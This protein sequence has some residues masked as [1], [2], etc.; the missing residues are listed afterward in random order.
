MYFPRHWF[1]LCDVAECYLFIGLFPPL[2]YQFLKDKDFWVY[3]IFMEYNT[4]P[5]T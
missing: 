3:F 5:G 4:E 2:D 1:G